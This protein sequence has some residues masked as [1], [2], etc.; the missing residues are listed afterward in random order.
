MTEP[1]QPP[2]APTPR[3]VASYGW[4]P[5]LPDWRDR[6]YLVSPRIAQNL[7]PVVDLRPICPPAIYDQGNLG[8]CTA[9]AIGAAIECARIAEGRPSVI[10][11][12]LFIYYNER[13]IERTV[14]IDSGAMIRDGIKTIAKQGACDETTWPYIIEKFTRR[15]SK[16][17]Y[18]EALTHRVTAYERINGD[19]DAMRG[20]LA[21]GHPFVIGF[22]VY[23]AFESIKVARTG[24]LNMPA[25]RESALGGHAV[26]TVGYDDNSRRF[27]V[28]N[29][30][31]ADWGLGGY[32]TVPYTYWTDPGL[33]GD[34]WAITAIA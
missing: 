27:L 17:A 34:R 19:L 3:R 20:A 25:T 11:S 22:S 7:P 13:V 5:D 26:L 14:R 24:E 29:S 9:N 12:R 23:T 10:P 16:A 1:P 32:F 33:A 6:L 18:A 8:S 15:P 21:A 2:P 4:I 31:G 30:W 28:R